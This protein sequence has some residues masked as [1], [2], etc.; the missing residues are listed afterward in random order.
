MAEKRIK[1]TA[2]VSPTLKAQIRELMDRDT[3]SEGDIVRLALT[4]YIAQQKS[5]A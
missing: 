1:V 4:A 3:R 2:V 5:A